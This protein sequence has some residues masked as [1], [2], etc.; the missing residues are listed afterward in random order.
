[1]SS[2]SIQ[3]PEG[4]R[5]PDANELGMVYD[6]GMMCGVDGYIGGE[7]SWYAAVVLGKHSCCGAES[8]GVGIQTGWTCGGDMAP[9]S[10]VRIGVSA[11]LGMDS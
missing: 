11:A 7:A 9:I 8:L 6:G 2:D 4:T 3:L 1:M 5:S 10:V